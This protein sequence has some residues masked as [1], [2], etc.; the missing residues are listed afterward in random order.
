MGSACEAAVWGVYVRQRC[1]GCMRRAC[2]SCDA[3]DDLF[4][5]SRLQ[6]QP[7][8]LLSRL[9]DRGTAQTGLPLPLTL[10]RSLQIHLAPGDRVGSG[11]IGWDRM[12]SDGI[13]WDRVGSDGIGWDRMGSDGINPVEATCCR[14]DKLVVH[15]LPDDLTP[16]RPQTWRHQSSCGCPGHACQIRDPHQL[17]AK[18]AT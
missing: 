10:P 18:R 16:N 1:G 12:G 14:Q 9:R 5:L 2:D 3:C 8:R 15:G 6:P 7:S 13:G 4:K 17:D 11:G